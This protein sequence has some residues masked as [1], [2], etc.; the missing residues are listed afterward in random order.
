M[1]CVVLNNAATH[2]NLFHNQIG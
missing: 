2:L 1:N